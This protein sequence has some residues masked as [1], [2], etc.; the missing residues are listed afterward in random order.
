MAP[1][2]FECVAELLW[3]AV[4]ERAMRALA[5][6]FLTPGCEC[7]PDIVQGAEPVCIEAFIAQP[8]VEALDV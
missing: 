8:S 5:V 4:V 2:P 1:A 7:T 3:G 6:V